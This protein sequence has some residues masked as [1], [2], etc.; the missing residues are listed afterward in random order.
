[1]VLIAT[2]G[3]SF[4][5]RKRPAWRQA[6]FP[7][8]KFTIRNGGKLVSLIFD[9]DLGPF[10]PKL[11][12]GESSPKWTGPTRPVVRGFLEGTLGRLLYWMSLL[13]FNNAFRRNR[14]LHGW[15]IDSHALGTVTLAYWAAFQGRG[16][17]V[18]IIAIWRVLCL[19]CAVLSIGLVRSQIRAL[20]GD[21]PPAS[22]PRIVLLGLVNWA[23][24]VA[25]FAL[26]YQA[27]NGSR[28][29]LYNSFT[30]QVTMNHAFV[31]KRGS[32]LAEAERYAAVAQISLS[33][34]LIST[35]IGMYVGLLAPSKTAQGGA[36]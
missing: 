19:L 28:R 13:S 35:L 31:A 36:S 1:M 16:P 10:T 12:A 4:L 29:W 18:W 30:T 2:T 3:W 27:I 15:Y 8:D 22:N 14:T 11:H 33:L 7:P 17:E 9:S 24:L 25:L 23:E 20:R 32:G 26:I 6:L 5:L 21:G 34:L